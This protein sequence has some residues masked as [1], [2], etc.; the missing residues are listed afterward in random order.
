MMNDLLR[1]GDDDGI[2][3]GEDSKKILENTK[4]QLITKKQEIILFRFAKFYYEK[5]LFEKS[6]HCYLKLLLDIDNKDDNEDTDASNNKLNEAQ[7]SIESI[8]FLSF[9]ADGKD[10]DVIDLIGSSSCRDYRIYFN[11][12]QL[13][14]FHHPDYQSNNK[15]SVT[16]IVIYILEKV[17]ECNPFVLESYANLSALHIKQNEVNRAV[18]VSLLGIHRSYQPCMEGNEESRRAQRLLLVSNLNVSL[19]KMGMILPAIR[20]TWKLMFPNESMNELVY[21]ANDLIAVDNPMKKDLP[22]LVTVI[23]VKVGTKYSSAYVNHLHQMISRSFGQSIPDPHNNKKMNPHRS[24][25]FR[26]IC[27]TDDP[28]GLLPE[29]LVEPIPSNPSNPSNPNN[30]NKLTGS[31]SSSSSSMSFKKWWSKVFIFSPEV[32]SKYSSSSSEEGEQRCFSPYWLFLDLDTIVLGDI[33][34]LWT[35]LNLLES[36][37]I[38]SSSRGRMFL[39]NSEY[40]QNESKFPSTLLFLSLIIFPLLD[41]ETAGNQLESDAV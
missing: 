10:Q 23:C 16:S 36:E 25:S 39:L 30:P 5:K 41:R 9:I 2:A 38:P 18:S 22:L 40:F 33:L 29:I 4:N 1:R 27:L 6:F 15:S 20:F 37:E 26:L 28:I 35:N 24:Y 19:R 34:S 32:I 12:A 14:I 11:L 31:S 3:A 21:N 13:F 8:S 7:R 17:I